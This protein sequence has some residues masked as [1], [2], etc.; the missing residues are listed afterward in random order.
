MKQVYD[1]TYSKY[2]PAVAGD[3]DKLLAERA[4][5][6]ADDLL[7]VVFFL[8]LPNFQYPAGRWYG[9][10]S[11]PGRGSYEVAV[12]IHQQ[13]GRLV[14]ALGPCTWPAG[15]PEIVELLAPA[16]ADEIE[17]A[18]RWLRS[19]FEPNVGWQFSPAQHLAEAKA[20]VAIWSW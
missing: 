14:P 12:G 7:Q 9:H 10:K 13:Y 18:A 8:Q 1:L 4:A 6:T 2:Y 19:V 15:G 20:G 3:R 5:G 11:C 16:T 17:F